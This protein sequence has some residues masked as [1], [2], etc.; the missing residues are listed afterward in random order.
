MWGGTRVEHFL[1]DTG[2]VG[3]S[4]PNPQTLSLWSLEQGLGLNPS[5]MTLSSSSP[6]LAPGPLPT[7]WDFGEITRLLGASVSLSVKWG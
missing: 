6:L 1:T 5:S 4:D 3:D 2:G 7:V